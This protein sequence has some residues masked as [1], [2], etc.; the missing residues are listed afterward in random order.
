MV[1]TTWSSVK[2][3]DLFVL[4]SAP[5]HKIDGVEVQV[6]GFLKSASDMSDQFHNPTVPATQSLPPIGHRFL[7]RPAQWMLS[8]PYASL[9]RIH[10][11]RKI[12]ST[13]GTS[14][15]YLALRPSDQ[16]IAFIAYSPHA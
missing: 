9:S 4:N 8:H 10:V 11:Y 16:I 15:L 6:L 7:G 12:S 2:S 3:E 5:R 13:F 1:V 14:N